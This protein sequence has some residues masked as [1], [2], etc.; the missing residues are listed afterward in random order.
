MAKKILIV[1]DNPNNRLLIRDILAHHSYEIFEAVNG[2]E[3]VKAA[4]EKMPDLIFMDIQMPVM[5][6][7]EAIK[8]LKADPSTK[9]IKIIALTSFAM[10]GDREKILAA[11]ANEYLSKPFDTRKLPGIVERVLGEG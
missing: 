9:Q 5:N 10:Q 2:A 3:G 4:K 7:L 8:I 6:G 11:G 1:E